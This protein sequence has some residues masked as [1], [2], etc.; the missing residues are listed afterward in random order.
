MHCKFYLMDCEKKTP[1]NINTNYP[2]Y[3]MFE[4][5]HTQRK[6]RLVCTPFTKFFLHLNK[7]KKL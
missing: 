1:K 6:N 5:G 3:E 7:K 2:V 4:A